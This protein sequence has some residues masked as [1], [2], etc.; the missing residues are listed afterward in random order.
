MLF[1]VGYL[2]LSVVSRFSC[3]LV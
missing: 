1:L 3:K 2:T